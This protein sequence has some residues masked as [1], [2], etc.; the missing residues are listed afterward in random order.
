MKLAHGLA[1]ITVS[2][3]ALHWSSAQ[4]IVLF[5]D[6]LSDNGNGYAGNAKYVL[7]TNQA[8]PICS[9]CEPN[10]P[11]SPGVCCL[12]FLS[13]LHYVRHPLTSTDLS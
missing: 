1:L 10:E 4:S 12:T 11:C 8:R 13:R 3:L 9:Q 5:G 2:H 7:R 6:S